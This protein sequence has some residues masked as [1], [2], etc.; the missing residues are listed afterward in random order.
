MNCNQKN[1]LII[2][3]YKKYDIYSSDFDILHEYVIEYTKQIDYV[4]KIN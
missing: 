2:N 1:E 3:A 4:N